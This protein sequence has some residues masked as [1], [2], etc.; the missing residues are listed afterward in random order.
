VE[1]ALAHIP[2]ERSLCST[3][4]SD[5]E[6]FLKILHESDV[7]EKAAPRFPV[8]EQIDVAPARRFA[9]RHGTEYPDVRGAVPCGEA[10][11]FFLL[12]LFRVS[13]VAIS[14]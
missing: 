13:S 2:V 1:N 12:P 3:M 9:A 6:R 5:A 4:H 8:D 14:L 7:I 11:D 10:Q